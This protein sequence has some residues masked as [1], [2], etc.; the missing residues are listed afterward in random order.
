MPHA[1]PEKRKAYLAEYHRKRKEADPEKV[2]EAALKRAAKYRDAHPERVAETNQKQY[3]KPGATEQRRERLGDVSR[4]EWK[5]ALAEK[6]KTH[7]EYMREWYKTPHGR[8]SK[9]AQNIKKRGVTIEQYEEAYEQQEGRCAI[10][11]TKR[12]K[13]GKDRLVV[14]HCHKGG[15]FRALLCANCNAGIGFLGESI[16]TMRNAI[17]YMQRFIAEEASV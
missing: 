7:A 5:A 11:Q 2:A 10:C 13:Y 1:D 15:G 12:S 8:R 3:Y 4:D 16:E 17:A 14:D 9:I 6:K